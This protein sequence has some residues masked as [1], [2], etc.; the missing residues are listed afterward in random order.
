[1]NKIL[2]S[3]FTLLSISAIQCTKK[4]DPMMTYTPPV[5][6]TPPTDTVTPSGK[7]YLALGDSYTIGQSVSVN[8]RFPAQT[9]SLL[10]SMN[11]RMKDPNYIAATGWTTD[12][13][14]A[15]IANN[16]PSNDYDVVTLLIG[17]NDQYQ[18][19]DTSGSMTARNTGA[20]ARQMTATVL[21][22]FE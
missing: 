7:S 9:V 12:N 22:D 8:E 15:A 21:A 16:N 17:V 5:I 19:R 2:F 6:V 4:Q 1:M 3:L 14:A 20:N 11:I 18:R 10:R 13:L